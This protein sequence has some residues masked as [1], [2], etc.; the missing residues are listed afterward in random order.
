MDE[1]GGI[2]VI[3]KDAAHLSCGQDDILGLGLRE[4]GLHRN[5]IE[6]VKF[7]TGA[8]ENVG[9]T[10]ASEFTLDGGAYE[11]AVASDVDASVEGHVRSRQGDLLVMS[12]R[13]VEGRY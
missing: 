12:V 13:S 10:E 2:C 5:S 6:K 9:V 7:S 3:G 4:K 1:V 11:T 8:G